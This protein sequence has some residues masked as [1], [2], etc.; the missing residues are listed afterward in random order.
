MAL[1]PELNDWKVQD[2][3]A[4]HRDSL[5]FF[6]PR[7]SLTR[8]NNYGEGAGFIGWQRWS[9]LM[10]FCHDCWP[11]SSPVQEFLEA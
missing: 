4:T 11:I 7:N 1:L 3:E 8:L 9:L 5:I 2:V 6:K 10:D